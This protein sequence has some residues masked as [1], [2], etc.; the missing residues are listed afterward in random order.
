MRPGGGKEKGSNYERDIGAKISLWIS[1]GERKD[2]LCRTVLSGGQFTMSSSGNAGDLM[3]QHILAIPFCSK[4]IIECKSWKD[5]E[6]VKFLV[7]EGELYKVGKTWWLVCKQNRSSDLVFMSDNY[8]PPVELSF[9]M[10]FN[11]TVFMF[12]LDDFLRVVSPATFTKIMIGI[13][14]PTRE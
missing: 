6:L 12:K 9:N 1:G 8:L 11:N 2:L 4:V 3:G 5:L 13:V 14:L 10:F 7:K